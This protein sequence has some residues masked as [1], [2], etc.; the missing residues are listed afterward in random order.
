MI[1][2]VVENVFVDHLAGGDVDIADTLADLSF[3]YC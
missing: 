1:D 2:A 3:C